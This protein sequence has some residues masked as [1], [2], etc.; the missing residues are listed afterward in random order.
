[1]TA[2]RGRHPE[3]LMRSLVCC[4]RSTHSS[5]SAWAAA[6]L[7]NTRSVRNS[8]R[9]ATVEPF[10]L[11]GR[12]RRPRL[13]QPMRDPVLA[14]DPVEQ[15]LR[16]RPIE[17]PGEHLAVIGQDLGGHPPRSQRHR[18]TVAYPLGRLA[19][20]HPRAHAEPGMIIDPGQRLGFRAIRQHEPTHYIHLPQLH[21]H[22]PLP[23]PPPPI[24]STDAPMTGISRS[25]T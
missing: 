7:A 25:S 9:N 16:R 3:R 14:T 19:W 11:A 10:D 4:S 6:R 13:G 22:P 18:Q 15:H 23:P 20:H 12:G 5:S 21:R 24:P 2:D 8:V 1:M 17:A